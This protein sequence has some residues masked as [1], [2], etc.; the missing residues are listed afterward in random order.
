MSR[1]EAVAALHRAL[2][3]SH[4]LLAAADGGDADDVLRLDAERL[5]LLKSARHALE[6]MAHEDLAVLRAIADLNARSIGRMEHRFRAKCRDMDML[7]AG[8]RALRAYAPTR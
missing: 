5:V 8:R 7:A 2:E 6:P 1:D 3:L 4:E